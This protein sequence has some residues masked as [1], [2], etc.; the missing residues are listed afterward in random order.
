MDNYFKNED[1]CVCCGKYVPEGSLVCLNCIERI[2]QKDYSK[3]QE[4]KTQTNKRK[5]T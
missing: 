5:E 2:S 4:Q 3:N 1:I